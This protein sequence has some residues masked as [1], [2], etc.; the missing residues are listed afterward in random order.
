M[1]KVK[2]PFSGKPEMAVTVHTQRAEAMRKI[3]E[4]DSRRILKAA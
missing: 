1:R 2:T 4:R 3:R